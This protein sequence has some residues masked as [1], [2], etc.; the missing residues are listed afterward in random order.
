MAQGAFGIDAQTLQIRALAVT[1]NEVGESPMAA[2]VL[3][4]IPGNEEMASFTG[5][6][7]LRHAGCT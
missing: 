4:Q 1:T 6:G 5:D 7:V 2:D 3:C